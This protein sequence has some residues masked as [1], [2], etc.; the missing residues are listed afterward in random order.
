M[1]K[2][3]S[4]SS[5]LNSS[6]PALRRANLPANLLSDVRPGTRGGASYFSWEQVK[7]DKNR[8]CYLGNTVKAASG[9]WMRLKDPFWWNKEEGRLFGNEKRDDDLEKVRRA[10]Q[11]AIEAMSNTTQQRDASNIKQQENASNSKQQRNASNS[12]EY[13]NKA[14]SDPKQQKGES[15]LFNKRRD[16]M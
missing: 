15:S 7:T 2:S 13:M 10:E 11:A 16:R 9:R 14:M 8:E 5:K 3:S 1:G 6:H 4:A 12:R